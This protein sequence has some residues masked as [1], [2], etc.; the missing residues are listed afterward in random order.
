MG[1][2]FGTLLETKNCSSRR[3]PRYGASMS[4]G[5][6]IIFA[7]ACRWIRQATSLILDITI[8]GPSQDAGT[9]VT[10]L[11]SGSWGAARLELLL[12]IPRQK[13]GC[14]A[15]SSSGHWPPSAADGC[16]GGCHS[17]LTR[18]TVHLVAESPFPGSPE[19]QIIGQTQLTSL[20]H[21]GGRRSCALELMLCW[22][23][24]I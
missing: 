21:A 17:H 19:Q 2:G 9:W 1:G 22:P 24:G 23:A 6:T 14:R 4:R 8:Y 15:R 7:L 11:W 20:H 3:A 10:F 18:S 5:A 12:A 16:H 13:P